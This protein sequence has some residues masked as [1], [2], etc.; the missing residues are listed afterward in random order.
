MTESYFLLN[1]PS[2][3]GG[4]RPHKEEE[5][6]RYATVLEVVFGSKKIPR[7]GASLIGGH[8]VAENFRL[9]FVPWETIIEIRSLLKTHL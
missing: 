4:G 3:A 9:N 2:Q 7:C 1:L 8:F 6:F 5:V